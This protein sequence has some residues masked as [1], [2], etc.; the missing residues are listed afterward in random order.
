MEQAGFALFDTA[1]GRCGI[2]WRAAGIAG[3]Q[4]PEA[5]DAAALRRLSRRFPGLERSAPP[6]AVAAAMSRIAAFLEGVGDDFADI[7]LASDGVG[8]FELAVYRETGKIPAGTTS[9]YGAIAASL[10]NPG[11]A[12]AVGQALGRNP[13]PIVVPCHRVTGAGGAMGGFSAPGGRATKLR[14]LEIEGALTV[15]SLPLFAP[16]R[17]GLTPR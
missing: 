14:L 10:G 4:L 9:T 1:I 11:D 3:V 12:R 7:A 8:A 6:P 17:T 2:A 15:D 16:A 5:A 13:W